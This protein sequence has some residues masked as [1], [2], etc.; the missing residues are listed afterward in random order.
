[1]LD[2][3][4]NPLGLKA[5]FLKEVR[6]FMK[7][8]M[9]TVLTPMVTV[10]LYLVV[11]AHV[12]EGR[13]VPDSTTS[14]SVFLVP[15]LLMMSVI[16]NAFANSSSSLIQ[17]KMNGSLTFLLLAPI[18]AFEIWLAFVGAAI[19]RGLLVG[20]GVWLIAIWF[21]DLPV[22]SLA[23]IFAFAALGGGVLGVLGMIAGIVS[24]KFDHLS[25][26]QN[27]VILPLSFLSGVFYSIHSL[28]PFWEAVS[29]LNPFFYMI[30]G[31]RQGF[32]GQ[33]D[34]SVGLSLTVVSGFFVAV[35]A[36]CLWMLNSGW[37]I[38]S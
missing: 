23:T 38:R 5:L 28:P 8:F 30:D 22:H 11:F 17:S 6:R 15:G 2:A 4:A 35:S 19:L 16:Q 33:A 27:F 10:L 13:Y 3:L 12:L 18:S 1:M 31:L 29:R 32:L 20:S 21:I 25:A 7:V 37:R 26:F 9:Q 36:L 14:Y 24:E 34:V